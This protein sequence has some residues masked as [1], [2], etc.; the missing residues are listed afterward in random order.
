MWIDPKREIKEH[1]SA[2]RALEVAMIKVNGL[3]HDIAHLKMAMIDAGLDPKKV[4]DASP[5]KR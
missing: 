4:L 3:M 5:P 1:G 2:E